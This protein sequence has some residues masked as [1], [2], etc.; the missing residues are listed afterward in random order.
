M[1]ARVEGDPALV[2]LR[3]H[4]VARLPP[5]QLQRLVLGRDEAD[6]HT[7]DPARGQPGAVISASSYAGRLQTAPAGTAKTTR[8]TSP[9]S[10][11]A[12]SR[13][14]FSVSAGASSRFPARSTRKRR[15][16]SFRSFGSIA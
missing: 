5:K 15:P 14:I 1:R 13:S 2:E 16:R 3:T 9:V 4:G 10:I 7:G 6:L 11:S 12:S 8:R